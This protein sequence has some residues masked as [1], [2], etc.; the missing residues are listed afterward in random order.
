VA[1]PLAPDAR[2]RQLGWTS[3][4]RGIRWSNTPHHKRF[5]IVH[6]ATGYTVADHKT[7]DLARVHTF[8]AAKAWAGIR[9]GEQD[10]RHGGLHD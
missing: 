9:V 10:V 6:T 4:R 7:G 2:L 3:I 1:D 5:S 8:A